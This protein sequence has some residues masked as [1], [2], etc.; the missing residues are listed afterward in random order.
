MVNKNGVFQ[1]SIA[2]A[3]ISKTVLGYGHYWQVLEQGKYTV[4]VSLSGFQ[5]LSKLVSVSPGAFT[6]VSLSLS[7]SQ[8]T[9]PRLVLLALVSSVLGVLLLGVVCFHRR[10]SGSRQQ[11]AQSYYNGFQLLSRDE[12]NVF[13]D[14]EEEEE[15]FE[16]FSGGV[17]QVGMRKVSQYQD[18]D[19]DSSQGEQENLLEM[20]HTRS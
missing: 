3:N 8:P 18:Q 10:G 16:F 14:D 9:L 7:R 6:H 15:E 4:S 1:V 2:E 5:P 17:E 20:G 11:R 19:S 13:H 12:R